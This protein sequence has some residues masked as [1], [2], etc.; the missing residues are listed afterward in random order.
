MKV[1]EEEE[2]HMRIEL[3]LLSG[4]LE[5]NINDL[6]NKLAKVY[7]DRERDSIK[8]EIEDQEQ[9]LDH[10]N[11][12]KGVLD[13]IIEISNIL[14]DKTLSD[15]ERS[16]YNHKRYALRERIDEEFKEEVFR[17]LEFIEKHYEKYKEE[18]NILNKI[19]KGK[20]K[21]RNRG[22]EGLLGDPSFIRMFFILSLLV[23][24]SVTLISLIIYSFI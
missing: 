5:S 11:R 22:P 15:E 16:L 7:I 24:F 9:F 23:I 3:S 13:S 21:K 10:V 2:N 19:P 12:L 18:S 17:R 20:R 4:F 1:K 6:K 8:L 14:N